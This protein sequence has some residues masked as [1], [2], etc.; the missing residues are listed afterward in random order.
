MHN[1]TATA[2][3]QAKPKSKIY[4]MFDGGGL[5]VKVKPCSAKYCRYDYRY[6]GT[7]RTL[8]LGVYPNVSLKEARNRHQEAR[9]L[10]DQGIDPARKKQAKKQIAY[11]ATANRF[12][13]V[14]A[15]WF[16]TKIPDKSESHRK[17]A[18]S[19]L[20]KDLFPTIGNGPVSDISALELLSAL[21]KIEARGA[22]EMVH[23]AKQIEG[24]VLA[25]RSSQRERN[26]TRLKTLMAL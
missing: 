16:E 3:K 26:V 6:M 23:R 11:Q 21:R 4:K 24:R 19:V 22:I 10:L 9:N 2:I 13:A 14:A 5:H 15:E 25:T 18:L 12:K 20:K 7:R 1:L 8:V 17:K